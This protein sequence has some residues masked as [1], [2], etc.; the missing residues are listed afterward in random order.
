MIGGRRASCGAGPACRGAAGR[1]SRAAGD[2]AD[3]WIFGGSG[4]CAG[5]YAGTLY[6]KMADWLADKLRAE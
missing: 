4:H 6:P 1:R 2:H 5:D 3:L